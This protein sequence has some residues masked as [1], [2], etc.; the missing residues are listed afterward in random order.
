ME[1]ESDMK[2]FFETPKRAFI[3]GICFAAFVLLGVGL[4]FAVSVITKFFVGGKEITM[5]KAQEIALSDAGLQASE[6]TFTKTKQEL[7]RGSY[8]YE[9]EFYTEN[10]EYEYEINGNACSI[11][12][13]SKEIFSAPRQYTF[14]QDD[15]NTGQESQ[16]MEEIPEGGNTD[17][18]QGNGS[19]IGL[20]QARSIAASHAGFTVADVSFSKSKMEKE[21]GST[22]YEIEFYKDGMEY[23]YKINAGTGEILEFDSEWDD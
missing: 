10:A 19:D 16:D 12:S 21:H 4:V 6:V 18:V 13:K 5:E 3:M 9:I 8:V 2:K 1:R 15:P 22:I 23:E 17:N 20:D 11:Y 7:E 14:V